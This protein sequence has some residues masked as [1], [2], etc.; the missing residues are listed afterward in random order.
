MSS[1]Q[2]IALIFFS[3]LLILFL[4]REGSD[5]AVEI[6]RKYQTILAF[7][8]SLTFGYGAASTQSY[9]AYL[10]QLLGINVINEGVSG[11][12]SSDG[13]KRLFKLLKEYQPDLIII[14]HGGNDILRKKSKELLQKNLESMVQLS[15]EMGSDVLLVSVPNLSLF[16]LDSLSLYEEVS[17]Q[18]GTLLEEN[19]LSD[20]LSNSDLKSDQI[21]PNAQGYLEMAKA[22]KM[23]IQER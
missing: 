6:D 3:I 18:Y 11:E 20:I 13:L 8:D 15:Q 21:H 7:G 17:Q 23:A 16:G 10:S 4:F 1:I 2:K 14:C 12:V 22:F 19:I 9:P 5:T